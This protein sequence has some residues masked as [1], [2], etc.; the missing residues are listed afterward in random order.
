MWKAT[1]KKRVTRQ[2]HT[3]TTGFGVKNVAVS[4]VSVRLSIRV[5]VSVGNNSAEKRC[6]PHV[7][8]SRQQESLSTCASAFHVFSCL[9]GCGSGK[10]SSTCTRHS[11]LEK[12]L[13]FAQCGS[14]WADMRP[15]RPGWLF[16]QPDTAVE[17]TPWRLD[18]RNQQ[19][20]RT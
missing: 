6:P 17:K 14:C 12:T 13:A 16:L 20:R 7:H 5:V 9:C 18:Q 2:F 11:S 10:N 1:G 8:A 15:M 19:W 3:S 4:I